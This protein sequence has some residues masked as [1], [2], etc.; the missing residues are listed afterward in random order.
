MLLGWAGGW[1]LQLQCLLHLE[2]MLVVCAPVQW[3]GP[4]RVVP[5]AFE[6]EDTK[7]LP[8][9]DFVREYTKY[10]KALP[11]LDFVLIRRGSTKGLQHGL[12]PGIQ[13]AQAD[14]AVDPS[15]CFS[16]CTPLYDCRGGGLAM[17][18]PLSRGS[19]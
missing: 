9:L 6:I 2:L 13:A 10:T 14:Q 19:S 18:G 15:K 16:Q 12:Q 11:H 1:R 8:H 5:P 4:A 7:A 17:E 3:A